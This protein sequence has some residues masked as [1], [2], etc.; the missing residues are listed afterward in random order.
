MIIYGIP[1]S[2]VDLWLLGACGTLLLVLIRLRFI[3]E[4]RN[5]DIF[6]QAAEKF[7]SAFQEELTRLK[8]DCPTVP[9]Y[10]I[11]SPARTK[12]GQAYA[13]FSCHLKGRKLERFRQA[14]REYYVFTSTHPSKEQDKDEDIILLVEK[15]EKLLEFAKFK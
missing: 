13:V 15:I 5:R 3:A 4:I 1:I 11:I 14:W 8:L 12:H 9:V 7:I 2:T 6:N 10:D